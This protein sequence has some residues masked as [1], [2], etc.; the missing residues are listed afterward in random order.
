MKKIKIL[1]ILILLSFSNTALSTEYRISINTN[2]RSHGFLPKE[3]KSQYG[4]DL[5]IS[6]IHKHELPK[7]RK[8][9]HTFKKSY[10]SELL[11]RT[12]KSVHLVGKYRLKNMVFSGT[13]FDNIIVLKSAGDNYTHKYLVRILHHEYS[14]ILME[15]RYFPKRE[16]LAVSGKYGVYGSDKYFLINSSNARDEK[17]KF[18]KKGFLTYYGT[19]SFTE[20]VNTYAEFFFMTKKRLIRIGNKHPRVRKKTEIMT[21]F[22]CGL[23]KEMKRYMNCDT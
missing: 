8:V 19:T 21:K 4:S 14:S 6:S 18:F 13:Y 12:L 22:Y 7:I 2:I 3:W 15:Y 11:K 10:P 9:I 17:A 23:H 1:L 16:W 20:D 5:K